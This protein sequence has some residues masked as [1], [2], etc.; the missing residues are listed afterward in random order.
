MDTFNKFFVALSDGKVRI[1]KP[2]SHEIT[3]DEALMFAAWLVV[4]AGKEDHIA[5]AIEAVQGT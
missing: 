3:P 2:P 4:M 5:A 1:I